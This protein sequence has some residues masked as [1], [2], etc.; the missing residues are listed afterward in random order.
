MITIGS[1]TRK[2]NYDYTRKVEEAHCRSAVLPWRPLLVA[3]NGTVPG[4]VC[5]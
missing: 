2:K 4:L 5:R 1:R 3:R